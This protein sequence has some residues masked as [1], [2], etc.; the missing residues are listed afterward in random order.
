MK[1]NKLSIF[2]INS[3]DFGNRT[4]YQFVLF[5]YKPLFSVIFFWFTKSDRVQDR[6]HTHAFNAISFKLFGRYTEYVLIDEESGA[7]EKN[8]RTQVIKYFPRNS[9]HAIG[10]SKRGC[11]TLLISGPWKATWKEWIN[12]EVK[13]YNWN[14][15]E[16][17]I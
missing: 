14:R 15:V 3:F 10:Q 7:F 13:E 11:L 17:I 16:Q 4:I 5:E 6:F 2:A 12:G 8:E 9:Y 1:G